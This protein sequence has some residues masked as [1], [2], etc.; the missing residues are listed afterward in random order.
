MLSTFEQIRDNNPSNNTR[1]HVNLKYN[2]I[3][4]K[5]A[6]YLAKVLPSMTELKSLNLSVNTIGS[7]GAKAIALALIDVNT[8][9]TTIAVLNSIDTEFVPINYYNTAMNI[10]EELEQY[11]EVKLPFLCELNLYSNMI[12]DKGAVAIAYALKFFTQLNDLNLACNR[13]GDN[14]A[15]A[16]ANAV[17]FMKSLK[18]L[19]LASNLIS[20]KGAIALANAVSCASKLKTLNLKYNK[21]GNEGAFALANVNFNI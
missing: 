17:P 9:N 1:Q 19:H 10:R 14:G 6:I 16:L 4:D 5:R 20:D 21:I 13:I 2:Y 11:Y 8:H 18:T 7:E 3:T 12:E 15:I